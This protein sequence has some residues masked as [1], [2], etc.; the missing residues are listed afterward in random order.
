MPFTREELEDLREGSHKMK[1]ITIQIGNTD[2][3][4]T[5]V[6][7]AAYVLTVKDTIL[8][9]CKQ[10]HFFGGSVNWDRWQNVAWVFE[11]SEEMIDSL[12][13]GLTADRKA[14]NQDSIAW[15][16]GETDFI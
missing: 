4:L 14:F 13:K 9:H 16:E 12:R 3:K 8:R 2:D 6:E 7:W 1:T 11:C 10:I 15:T 5:Q